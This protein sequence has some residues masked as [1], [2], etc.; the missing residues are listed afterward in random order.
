MRDE[1]MRMPEGWWRIVALYSAAVMAALALG[2]AGVRVSGFEPPQW[3]PQIMRALGDR[4]VRFMFVGSSRVG[5]AVNAIAFA[6]AQP[7]GA[8]RVYGPVFNSGHGFSTIVSH[9][10][11]LRRMADAGQL[12]GAVV[13][14]EAAG[15]SPDESTWRGRWYY[16]EA[17]NFLVSV[18]GPRDLPGLWRSS[19]STDEKVGA[20]ARTLLN[21]SNLAVYAEMVRVSGLG[22]VYSQ[23]R[24]LQTSAPAESVLSAPLDVRAEGGVR[25]DVDDLA[26][27]SRAAVEEGAR[28]L[29]EQRFVD[30]WDG[31]V[32]ADL[33]RTVRG[34]GGEVVF[35]EMPLSPPMRLA[36]L[37]E[38]GRRN[39]A[40]F[41]AWA[42]ANGIRML[43][44]RREFPAEAFPDVWH[45][46][47]AAAGIFT[48][49][50]IEAWTG[51]NHNFQSPLSNFQ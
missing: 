36:S 47:A 33:V 48:Q 13:F 15:G 39:R 24:R 18:A 17:P 16:R 34:G 32:A 6:Q 14:V 25:G 1:I 5:A 21:G 40:S 49:D 23:A 42:A 19:M 37:S 31:T 9:A 44:A 35:F 28:M 20:T 30:N 27:I 43:K 11:G 4:P 29:R 12:R 3:Y 26:R 51:P 2:E 41:E 50:L 10:I 46:S 45:M 8:D 38:T 22:T 7:P